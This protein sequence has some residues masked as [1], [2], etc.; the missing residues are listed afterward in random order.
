MPLPIAYPVVHAAG[1]Y[2]ATTAAGTY[3]AGTLS[4]TYAGAF[5]AGN[6]ALTVIVASGGA[7]TAAVGAWFGF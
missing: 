2:I 7:A 6:T 4:A 5:V 1:G 3:I